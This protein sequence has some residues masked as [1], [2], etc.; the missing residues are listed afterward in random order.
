MLS[1]E[2]YTSSHKPRSCPSAIMIYA[3][4][5]SLSTAINKNN[6][7]LFLHFVLEYGI[8]G[9]VYFVKMSTAYNRQGHA[10]NAS[11]KH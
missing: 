9:A 6:N 3:Y 8:S 2:T 5:V 1:S 7:Y 4:I 10:E 11:I